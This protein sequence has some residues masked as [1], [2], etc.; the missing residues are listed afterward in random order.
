[1]KRDNDSEGRS[2]LFKTSSMV[3][4]SKPWFLSLF[5]W[6]R[7]WS[8]AKLNPLANIT[9]SPVPVAEIWTQHRMVVPRML[10]LL[11]HVLIVLLAVIPPAVAP[12]PLPKGVINVALYSPSFLVVPI[13]DKSGGGGGGKRAST[14]T[15]LGKLPRPSDK[16]F[17][18]PDPEPTKNLDPTLI[19]EPTVVAP[20]LTT[21]P[22]VELFTLGDPNG[23]PSLPS[24]GPGVG[25]G[26]GTGHG[27]GDGDGDGP[28]VGPGENG[29]VGGRPVHIGGGVSAPVLLT[30]VLPEY[31]EEAR[32]A[33]YQGT[34]VLDTIVL[35]DG[36]VQVI[37]VARSIGFGL[38]QKASEA[39]LK[40]KFQ[41]G[42]IN[43]NPVPVALNVQV[44]FNLR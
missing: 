40:W 23:I 17:V 6:L 41:P 4:Q 9:A 2:T 25:N 16:Q 21:L 13:D 22:P 43:G 18:P 42:R 35:A 7:D 37:R 5:D 26:I 1:M 38:D 39:V 19:V 29:G 31:S 28:G 24:V 27:H 33:R 15:S 20:Q 8:T 11:V 30:Q 12:K 44:N 10:S 14:P 34:V 3:S 36:S 32:K